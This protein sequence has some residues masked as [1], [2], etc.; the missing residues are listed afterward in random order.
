MP[1]PKLL[2]IGVPCGSISPTL[3]NCSGCGN[4][5]PRNTIALTTVNCVVTPQMPSPST[6]TA[7]KQNDLSLNKTRRP[8]RTSCQNELNII[9]TPHQLSALC[10]PLFSSAL[11]LRPSYVLLANH[12]PVVRSAA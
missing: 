8:T 3:I 1:V 2:F 7:R 6:S 10:F 5:N 12:V 4:E 9:V 11:F